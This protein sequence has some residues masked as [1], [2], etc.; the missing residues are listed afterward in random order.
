MLSPLTETLDARE[1]E[2]RSRETVPSPLNREAELVLPGSVEPLYSGWTGYIREALW[3]YYHDVHESP[4][5][6]S[7]N[8]LKTAGCME[9]FSKHVPAPKSVAETCVAYLSP[10]V[11]LHAYS[12]FAGQRLDD[13]GSS[14]MVSGSCARTDEGDWD[15]SSR[16]YMTEIVSIGSSGFV[17]AMRDAV[18]E[19]IVRLFEAIGVEGA[20]QNIERSPRRG[21]SRKPRSSLRPKRQN[22]EFVASIDSKSVAIAAVND[23]L[24]YFGRRF[25]ILDVSGRPA[26][27]FCAAFNIERLAELGR[28]RWGDS[29]C[30]WPEPLRAGANHVVS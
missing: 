3:F 19:E 24:D 18:A 17:C 11:C 21:T 20:F 26:H 30:D 23:H 4:A 6:I 14:I 2:A 9:H 22:R 1:K 25:D 28:Q 16:L 29:L 27:A 10:A 8:V 15:P 7:R 12:M 13:E 5:F